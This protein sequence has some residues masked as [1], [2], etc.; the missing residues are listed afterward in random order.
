MGHRGPLRLRPRLLVRLYFRPHLAE[1]VWPS[2]TSERND[3]K[4]QVSGLPAQSDQ[5]RWWRRRAF[6]RGAWCLPLNGWLDINNTRRKVSSAIVKSVVG[7]HQSQC[8]GRGAD[9]GAKR[10]FARPSPPLPLPNDERRDN[11]YATASPRLLI[12]CRLA[13][14]ATSSKR[15]GPFPHITSHHIGALVSCG[16]NSDGYIAHSQTRAPASALVGC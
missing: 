1:V 3:N 6:S 4:K 5:G 9:G 7:G 12:V 14:A 16:A 2:P 11:N 8:N 15:V 10:Q 13:V